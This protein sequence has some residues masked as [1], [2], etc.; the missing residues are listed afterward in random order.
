MDNDEQLIATLELHGWR[1]L[2]FMR[3]GIPQREAVL[4]HP[5]HGLIIRGRA[6]IAP[7]QAVLP[8]REPRE[9]SA[10]PQLKDSYAA[11]MEAVYGPARSSSYA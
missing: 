4:Y 5:D 10:I 11:A 8:R 2:S 7:V 1:P 9:W 6:P 3:N